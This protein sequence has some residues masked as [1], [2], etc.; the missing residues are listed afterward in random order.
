MEADAFDAGLGAGLI[1]GHDCDFDGAGLAAL[2]GVVPIV[3]AS[4]VVGVDEGANEGVGDVTD[5]GVDAGD[6]VDLFG[7]G[8]PVAFEVDFPRADAGD[9][10][11]EF[12]ESAASDG[13]ALGGFD[14]V[15]VDD[16]AAEVRGSAAMVGIDGDDFADPAGVP[17]GVEEPVLE[18]VVFAAFGRVFAVG[19]GGFAVVGVDHV[20]PGG[21]VGPF[22]GGPAGESF[23]LRGDVGEAILGGVVLPS[24]DGEGLEEEAC[25]VFEF[26]FALLGSEPFEGL[27]GEVGEVLDDG[28]RVFVGAFAVSGSGE[29]DA[30]DGFAV[31]EREWCEGDVEGAP[32]VRIVARRVFGADHL[33]VW[34]DASCVVVGD[35]VRA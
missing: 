14:F 22:G 28:E 16:D 15:D 20:D 34:E 6:G 26:A 18:L 25:T 35:E 24:D 32:A 19:G 2:E 1:G 17:V 23:G 29:A 31:D 11:G 9:F 30:A 8:D 33:G 3:V 13:V 12:E 4:A 5:V 7:P 27:C 21:E 10:V